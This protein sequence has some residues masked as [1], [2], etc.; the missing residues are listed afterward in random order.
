MNKTD[1]FLRAKV[2]HCSQ[3]PFIFIW[4]FLFHTAEALTSQLTFSSKGPECK[5]GTE[6]IKGERAI[7]SLHPFLPSLSS[8]FLSLSLHPSLLFIYSSFYSSNSSSLLLH[9]SIHLSISPSIHLLL[10]SFVCIAVILGSPFHMEFK[11][12]TTQQSLGMV[13]KESPWAGG[14]WCRGPDEQRNAHCE[15]PTQID[16]VRFQPQLIV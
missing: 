4:V 12:P 8:L 10:L 11:S 3:R 14:H 16:L 6:A 1:C 7:L 5:A 2:L 13:L 15:L 9:P